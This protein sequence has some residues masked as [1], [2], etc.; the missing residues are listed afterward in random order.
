MHKAQAKLHLY[1]LDIPLAVLLLSAILGILPAFNRALVWT[2]LIILILCG[3]MYLLV[4]RVATS[5]SWSLFIGRFVVIVCGLVAFYFIT[6]YSHYPGLNKVESISRLAGWIGKLSPSMVFW[7]PVANSVATLLE[8]MFFLA[9]GMFLVEEH[10]GWR[11]VLGLTASIVLLALVVSESRGAW[12]AVGV[13]GLVWLAIYFRWAKWLAILLALGMFLVIILVVIQQDI[14]VMGRIPLVNR[15][16]APLFIRPDRLEVYRGSMDLIQ[17]MPFTGIGLGNQFAMAYSRYVLG[18]HV[19]FLYYSHNLFLEV[20]L[21]Q[22]LLGIFALIWI[23]AALFW[24]AAKTQLIEHNLFLESTWIGLIAIFL[25][26]FTDARQYIDLWCWLPAFLLLGLFAA[27]HRRQVISPGRTLFWGPLGVAGVFLGIVLVMLPSLPASWQAN[28]GSIK[29]AWLE[30]G[31]S[32]DESQKSQLRQEA[33]EDFNRSIRFRNSQRTAHLRL[34]MI[35]MDDEQ[36]REAVQHLEAAH[37]VD[38]T[39]PATIKT[40]GFAYV[41]VGE[42]EKARNLLQSVPKIVEELN[43]WGWWR[44][45]RQ[46]I[47]LS[48]YAYQVSLLLN[49]GQPDVRQVIDALQNPR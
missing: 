2:P 3:L 43:Y 16:L 23:L 46:Q 38:N 19:P 34:G 28:L 30:L 27:L 11:V 25:H 1:P 37:R 15:V 9:V 35:L 21:E 45:N 24:S 8:G 44:G 17:D 4:S 39:N 29:Q 6:Q 18:V 32:L 47:V 12:L 41:W 20:W 49:P 42:L 31:P 14:Q 5:V 40:L 26:G 48:K 13:A 10:I 36:F 22:G 33:I 7:A